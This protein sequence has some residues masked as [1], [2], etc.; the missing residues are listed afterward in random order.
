[1][2]PPVRQHDNNWARSNSEKA[3]VFGKHLANVFYPSSS[4]IS[5]E[6]ENMLIKTLE[7]RYQLEPSLNIITKREVFNIIKKKYRSQESSWI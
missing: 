5:Q 4:E 7:E 3:D 6:E 2:L 1:M